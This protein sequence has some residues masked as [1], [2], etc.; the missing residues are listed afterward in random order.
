MFK[1]IID[2]NYLIVHTVGPYRYVINII[3]ID[4]RH[5]M[6]PAFLLK[7]VWVE[8][9]LYFVTKHTKRLLIGQCVMRYPTR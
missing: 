2:T 6:C 3:F 8:S 7:L 9:L 4:L 1:Y 5:K